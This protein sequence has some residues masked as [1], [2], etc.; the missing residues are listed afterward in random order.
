MV[1]FLPITVT[2][3]A[4]S[5]LPGLFSAVTWT[6]D[7]TP[8]WLSGGVVI[9]PLNHQ[10]DDLHGQWE[11]DWNAA[12]DDVD[13]DKTGDRADIDEP[14]VFTAVTLYATDQTQ[15]G[16]LSAQSR[17]EARFRAEHTLALKAQVDYEAVFGALILS[18]GPVSTSADDVVGAIS[19]LEGVL[20]A[21]GTPGVIH[22]GT[23][24]VAPA[25]ASRAVFPGDGGFYTALGNRVV[26]GGGYVDELGDVL[27][28]TSPL[29]GWKT[30]AVVRDTIKHSTNQY[31]AVAEQSFVVA[32]E[33]ILG[34]AEI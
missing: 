14:D 20:G 26:F 17:Q 7:P 19:H 22:A 11:E 10:L 1:D 8:R 18:E 33:A 25:V 6:T 27:M 23:N 4:V 9:R 28:A 5:P 3:P 32:Y 34:A 31:V 30:P 21:A 29:L 13:S 24:W 15:C 12:A 16:D 2:A